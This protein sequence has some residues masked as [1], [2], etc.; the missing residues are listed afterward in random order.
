[1]TNSTHPATTQP[2]MTHLQLRVLV[3]QVRQHH[4]RLA[5]RA[6]LREH[7][8]V[9]HRLAH[10]RARLVLDDDDLLLNV[11]Y[12]VVLMYMVYMVVLS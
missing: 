2:P 1:M 5:H 11:M 6:V 4:E 10:D 12:V 8:V 9:L 3:V 7:V